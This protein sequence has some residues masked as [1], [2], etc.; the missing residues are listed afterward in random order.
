VLIKKS[1]LRFEVLNDVYTMLRFTMVLKESRVLIDVE[2]RAGYILLRL[3]R[4]LK[5]T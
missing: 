4:V 1:V 2:G 5:E 3:A